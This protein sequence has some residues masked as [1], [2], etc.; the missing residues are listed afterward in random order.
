MAEESRYRN[1]FL[2][3]PPYAAA[4]ASRPLEYFG[5]FSFNHLRLRQIRSTVPEAHQSR[6]P[7]R[8]LLVG[9]S[10]GDTF[11]LLTHFC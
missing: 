7:F 5:T 9:R 8:V 4:A 1:C 3:L 2:G 10:L 6:L 11:P